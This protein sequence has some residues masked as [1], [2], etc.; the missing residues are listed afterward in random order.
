MTKCKRDKAKEN[1]SLKQWGEEREREYAREREVGKVK[2]NKRSTMAEF[3][4]LNIVFADRG[5][6]IWDITSKT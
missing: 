6:E 1:Y 4:R 2:I 3:H 5:L